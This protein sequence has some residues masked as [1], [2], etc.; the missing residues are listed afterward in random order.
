MQFSWVPDTFPGFGY[1][2]L[3]FANFT[4]HPAYQGI[5]N[6]LSNGTDSDSDDGCGD[7]DDRKKSSRAEGLRR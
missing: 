3:Y 1:A 4:R 5:V 2:T 6:A 7:E